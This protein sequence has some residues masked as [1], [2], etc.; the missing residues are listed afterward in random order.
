MRYMRLCAILGIAEAKLRR[1][2]R[3]TRDLLAQL[4]RFVVHVNLSSVAGRCAEVDIQDTGITWQGSS[5]GS[6]ARSPTRGP[7][8]VCFFVGVVLM[9]YLWIP[10]LRIKRS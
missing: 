9:F 7:L 4:L 2:R 3:R 5:L 8:R 6:K 1:S 10:C